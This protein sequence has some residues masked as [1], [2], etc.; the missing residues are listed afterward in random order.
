V[1]APDET[2][3]FAGILR[4]RMSLPEVLLWKAIKARKLNGLSFRRQHPI[5]PY[6]LDFFCPAQR[7]CL[8]VDGES[9]GM[10]DRPEKDRYR[11]AWLAA[12][13][14]RTL[15]LSAS[16][17]LDDIDDATGTILGFLGLERAP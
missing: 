5:G 1:D 2:R 16:L 15:R 3:E 7:L 8:E 17:V 11:D 14:I 12:K 10:G 6:V 9:H 13:G 4:K